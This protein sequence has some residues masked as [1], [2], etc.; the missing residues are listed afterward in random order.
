MIHHSR[1]NARGLQRP[2][3]TLRHPETARIF[4]GRTSKHRFAL[5]TRGATSNIRR[6]SCPSRRFHRFFGFLA[7]SGGSTHNTW[8]PSSR[9]PPKICVGQ[10]VP[11]RGGCPLS[12]MVR[13][14]GQHR[15][16]VWSTSYDRAIGLA[17]VQCIVCRSHGES[18]HH[19]CIPHSMAPRATTRIKPPGPSCT[20][21]LHS[22]LTLGRRRAPITFV[23]FMAPRAVN[24]VHRRRA[25]HTRRPWANVSTHSC[26][27]ASH[28]PSLRARD[29]PPPGISYRALRAH[30]HTHSPPGTMHSE[31][32]RPRP[33]TLAAGHHVHYFSC[34]STNII[35]RR[36]A[37]YAP[38][39]WLR[40]LAVRHH[41]ERIIL[42]HKRSLA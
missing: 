6:A 19:V 36:L 11:Q 15:P 35:A 14:P 9:V 29:H 4:T 40:A 13:S 5:P 22:T 38:H 16:F 34:M 18:H 30:W 24:H 32:S 1:A 41:T 37:P 33:C 26:R 12:A 25:Q 8:W 20:S 23:P 17:S 27:R 42:V 39:P 28:S 31:P 3:K 21:T 7:P 2:N 10:V